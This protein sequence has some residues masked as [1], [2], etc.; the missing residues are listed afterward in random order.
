MRERKS[1]DLL[2][3]TKF[4]LVT[5]TAWARCVTIW[6]HQFLRP[7]PVFLNVA[8]LT[9]RPLKRS[10]RYANEYVACNRFEVRGTI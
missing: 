9:C 7:Y 5:A 3:A 1:T 6:V 8:E 2:A 10:S 4:V